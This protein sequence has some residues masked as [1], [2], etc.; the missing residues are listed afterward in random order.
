[1]KRM[2]A[3]FESKV[4]DF[5]KAHALS[6]TTDKIL[7]AV[8]GGADSTALLHLM[9]ALKAMGVLNSELI[10]VHLNHQLRGSEGDADEDFVI[11]QAGGLNVPV[12]TGRFDVRGF[13]DK[14]KLSIETA[15]RELR[16]KNLLDIAKANG[17][18]LVATGHQKND[19]AETILQR[20][21]RGTGFRGLGGIWPRRTFSAGIEFIRPL[22]CVTRTEIVDY[23]SQKTIQWRTDRTNIECGY[24]R[25]YIRHCLLPVLQ[26]QCSDSVVEEL[27][28]L[29]CAARKFY[30]LICNCAD[31]IWPKLAECSDEKVTLDLRMFSNKHPAVKVELIRRSLAAIGC[32][33]RDLAQKHYERILQS[34]ERNVS[35]NGLDLPG[36]FAA[37]R[38]YNNLTFARIERI[39]G[40][41]S[42][43]GESAKVEV[44]G[45]TR[46]AD[47]L[48][49]ATILEPD[50]CDVKKF[51]ERKSESVEWFDL[52]EI[53]PPLVA[54]FRKDGDKFWPL[55]L[56]SQKKV[57]KF[58]TAAKVPQDLRRKVLVVADSEK[59]IW[60]RPIR[61]SEQTRITPDTQKILQ[62][63]VTEA[64]NA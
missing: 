5:I 12:I 3:E 41:E 42:Q 50:S 14:N 8:S 57:G 58:L 1:M 48:I 49:E 17:C 26:K 25:N 18:D 21:P 34:A 38:E 30:S 36:G 33:E 27:S 11:R 60:L 20:L 61:I 46:F 31:E 24:R 2:L 53:K 55:G 43:I 64:P 28:E 6:R 63:Q 47:Y 7:L 10:C 44:P 52:D 37:W 19:N 22:L 23:L 54:R 56:A 59:I 15:A 9:C 40:P 32:G 16:I 51:K 62:L 4:A 45:R 29:A 35:D 13:A 39:S